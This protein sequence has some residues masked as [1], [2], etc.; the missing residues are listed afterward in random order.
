MQLQNSSRSSVSNPCNYTNNC[1]N[2]KDIIPPSRFN[3]SSSQSSKPV[4]P[5]LETLANEKSVFGGIF[6]NQ[7]DKENKDWTQII[8]DH[9]TPSSVKPAILEK[10]T[11]TKP[12][13]KNVE[14]SWKNIKDSSIRNVLC[15]KSK[16]GSGQKN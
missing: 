7:I 10:N 3:S 14:G 2:P 13:W 1:R 16:F 11:L 4:F 12:N 9:T 6:A 5:N 8:F 15:Q